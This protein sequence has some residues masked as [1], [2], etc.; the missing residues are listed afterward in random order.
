MERD[1]V[2][3]EDPSGRS[4][5]AL[6]QGTLL[7]DQFRVGRVLGVGGF[8]ITYLA[9]DEVLEMVVAVKE[10]LPRNIAVRKTGTNT[11]QP[12]S[13]SGQKQD[14][15]FGLK[16]FLQEARTLA[17]FEAHPNIVRVRTFFEENGTGYLVMN[18]YEGRTLAEYLAARNGFLP[19]EEAL[20]IMEQVLEGLTAVHEEDILHRDIDP[21]N[22]YLADNGTVVLLDFGA[23][24]TAVGERTQSMS[25]VLKRGYAPHEQYHSH[26]DQG[27]WTDVYACSATLYRTL[28]G[29]KPPEAAARILEDDMA[30]PNELV[31][32]L[33]AATNDAVVEG[34]A[35]HP[36]ERPQ[37]IAAFADLLP[38]PPPEAE[39]GWIGEWTTLEADPT[40]PKGAAA[41]L[42]VTASHSCRLYVDGTRAAELEARETYRLGVEE[43]SHRLRAIRTDQSRAGTATVTA[44]G[45]SVTSDGG[46]DRMSLEALMWQ[47]VVS[48]SPDEPIPV[49]IDFVEI[50]AERP[51]AGGETADVGAT[52]RPDAATAR[53]AGEEGP[54]GDLRVRTDRAADFYVDGEEQGRLVPDHEYEI[55]LAPGEHRLRAERPDGDAQWR[56]A[57]VVEPGGDRDVDV[58]LA[59]REEGAA[60][61]LTGALPVRPAV[62]GG[63]ALLAVFALGWWVFSNAA[64][65]PTPDS[66]LLSSR[67][68][69]VNVTANDTD[70][71]GGTVRVTAAG[72]VPDS[73]AEVTPVDSTRVRVQLA[74]DFA[75]TTSIPYEV[76]DPDGATARSSIELRVPFNGVRQPVA[77]DLE[78]PQVVHTDSLGSDGDLDVL[79]AALGEQSLTWSENSEASEPRFQ[80]PTAIETAVDGVVDV[81]TGDLT[82]NGRV[83]VISASLRDDVLAWYENE[84]DG[85]FSDARSL[86][87]EADGAMAVRAADLDRDGDTDVVAG[88]LLDE[89]VTWYENLGDG[90]FAE[91][92]VVAD[93][94]SGLETLNI[95]DLDNDDVPDVLV[96]SYR[97][98]TIARY[99][100]TVSDDSVRFVERPPVGTNL[101]DPI[102]VH[103][104]DLLGNGREDVL[105]GKAGAQPLVL[106]E[107]RARGAN[108]PT[109]GNKRILSTGLETIEE[110]GTGDLDG[111]GDQDIFV[112]AFG[113]DRVVWFE[114][115]GDGTFGPAEPIATDVPDVISLSVADVDRDGDVD[116]LVASQTGNTVA[117]YENFLRE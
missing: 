42:R 84:G 108:Q 83:D 81:A 28:T 62:I 61:A 30:P 64:P 13:S 94:V 58:A 116:V 92:R 100:S 16:R 74:A 82:G 55:E 34:L 10:Y 102:E 72:P 97:D 86:D 49:G 78:Q 47:E 96:V 6:D 85:T 38:E 107:N 66:V 40:A 18:F 110:I 14:F 11:I 71:E 70:P 109:F 76:A 115:L 26:G 20:L 56:R 35:V 106:F 53:P 12:L 99:E 103:T 25:V 105:A 50:G 8:G 15:E 67:E 101:R 4:P 36:D 7:D 117:W 90:R 24:R 111:D 31:P 73:V 112:A 63:G 5:L 22:V 19:E 44:S 41:E 52:A 87:D 3:Q 48:A 113:S 17:K 2:F 75:G 60:E 69:V 46:S 39:P 80:P 23:A 68:T 54:A 33:S 93:S 32:S 1:V 29:Y 77:D 9:V 91:G 59:D 104:A 45:T 95:T 65:V 114:N 21:N 89:T 88:A 27:P 98:N 37:T 57:V 43:G 79:I 51:E